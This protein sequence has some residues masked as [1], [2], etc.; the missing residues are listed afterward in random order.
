MVLQRL[1]PESA[2]AVRI[3]QGRRRVVEFLERTI[4]GLQ[5]ESLENPRKEVL[6]LVQDLK[7]RFEVEETE[8]FPPALSASQKG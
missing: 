1:E 4:V 6:R 7:P 3:V 8:V 5:S 2:E